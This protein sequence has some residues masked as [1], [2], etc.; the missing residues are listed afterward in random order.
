M[1]LGMLT[2]TVRTYLAGL[3]DEAKVTFSR[4]DE[5]FSMIHVHGIQFIAL[6]PYKYTIV[7]ILQFNWIE[8]AND[9]YRY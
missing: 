7:G 9:K 6:L 4:G 3:V 8:E 5:F 2:L 1:W